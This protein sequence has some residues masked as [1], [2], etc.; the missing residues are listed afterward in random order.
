MIVFDFGFEKTKSTY[1]DYLK[2]PEGGKYQLIDGEIIEMPSSKT[3][4]QKILLF[5]GSTFLFFIRSKNLG[6]VF[7]APMDVYLS[8]TETYQPDV[9]IIL[10]QNTS[11]IEENRIKGAPDLVVEILSPS[12]AYYD[13]RHK[14]NT[15]EASGVKEYWILDPIEKSLEIYSLVQ[16]KFILQAEYKKA[17]VA[18]SLLIAGLEINLAEVF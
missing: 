14:K 13:L 10:N 8:D 18:K 6:E 3:I 12:T 2:T 4:H 1:A 7:V 16:N 17:D 5:I 15:Y 9:F 11:I